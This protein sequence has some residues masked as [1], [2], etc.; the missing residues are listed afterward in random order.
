MLGNALLVVCSMVRQ[1]AVTLFFPR[2]IAIWGAEMSP[3]ELY[4]APQCTLRALPLAPRG[5]RSD[6][7]AG[8]TP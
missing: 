7:Q 6:G 8:Q 2:E 4:R 3:R 5:A 1:L